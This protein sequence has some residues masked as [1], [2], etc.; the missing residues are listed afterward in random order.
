MEYLLY[1]KTFID[2]IPNSHQGMHAITKFTAAKL[3]ILFNLPALLLLAGAFEIGS[4][5]FV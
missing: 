1:F 5:V 3:L 4:S 2:N